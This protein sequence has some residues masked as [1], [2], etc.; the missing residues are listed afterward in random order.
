MPTKR[1]RSARHRRASGVEVVSIAQCIELLIGPGP[2]LRGANPSAFASDRQRRAAW[3]AHRAALLSRPNQYGRRP[4]A[5]WSYE[6]QQERDAAAEAAQLIRLRV[7]GSAEL[8]AI[9]AL[10]RRRLAGLAR[11]CDGVTARGRMQYWAE[12]RGA[13]IP[14][15]F[16]PSPEFMPLT[17]DD[18]EDAA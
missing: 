15:D 11:G 17:R 8:A 1:T 3:V 10:W 18:D 5:W 6:A 12:R 7:V 4:W 16:E 14:D 2:V 13:G 9:H